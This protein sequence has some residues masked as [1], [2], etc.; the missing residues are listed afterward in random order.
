MHVWNSAN[1][2]ESNIP[3]QISQNHQGMSWLSVQ[4]QSPVTSV[5]VPW[6]S[7]RIPMSKGPR[8]KQIWANKEIHLHKWRARAGDFSIT[9]TQINWSASEVCTQ[10]NP[11]ICAIY[12]VFLSNSIWFI[13]FHGQH[14]KL[15]RMSRYI[16]LNKSFRVAI[17]LPNFYCR[18][19]IF[20]AGFLSGNNFFFHMPPVKLS[21]S[22]LLIRYASLA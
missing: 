18:F 11:W 9:N 19:W 20:L 22:A 3:H 15:E 10:A 5:F 13:S 1:H 6:F 4:F 14:W 2:H 12:D 21:F 8:V 16:F 17:F 7:R